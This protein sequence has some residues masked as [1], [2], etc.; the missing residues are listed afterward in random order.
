MSRNRHQVYSNDTR[1]RWVAVFGLQWQVLESQRLEPAADVSGAMAAAIE[2]LAGEGEAQSAVG[3]IFYGIPLAL[4][5][6]I[7]AV[8][9]A[10]IISFA[11]VVLSNRNARKNLK[12]QLGHDAEERDRERTMSLRREVY[13]N[14]AEAMVHANG[15]LGRMTDIENDQRVL[16]QEF[17]TDLGKIA[18]IHIVG[19]KETVEAVMN[20]VN[21]LAPCFIEL[22]S[23]RTPLL[24]TKASIAH[25]QTFI[26]AAL[27]E[28]KRFTA[29]LQQLNL[30]GVTD[31]TKRDPI[32]AQSKIASENHES[33][34]AAMNKLWR[35]QLEGI[36]GIVS[37][38]QTVA[39]K[40]TRLLPPA[41]L[42]VRSE[43][44]LPLD[45]AWYE[46]KWD[47]Q[48]ARVKAVTGKVLQT[49]RNQID[50]QSAEPAPFNPPPAP[51][52]VR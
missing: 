15:L 52:P 36:E 7:G 5:V 20:Y 25:E 48:L 29:M 14:A 2:R 40:V 34:I 22:T 21:T 50:K 44:E 31:K 3:P 4:W 45:P 28:R 47:E 39:D 19:T 38:L 10:P 8:V 41:I 32:F 13:L 24:I 51:P 30:D 1:P 18:K 11:G 12:I 17:A 26:D 33:H 35:Q 9:F 49:L 42:A 23:K 46:S 6:A 16:G 27:A 43:M 37:H